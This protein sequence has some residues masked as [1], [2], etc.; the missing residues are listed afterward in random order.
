M[1]PRHSVLDVEDYD[2]L[3]NNP[4]ELIK[5]LRALKQ[6]ARDVLNSCDKAQLVRAGGAGAMSLE[7]DLRASFYLRVS[8]WPVEHLRNVL[9]GVDD[10]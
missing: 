6:A 2:H 1:S 4:E 7:N 3:L 10:D 9:E 8:A 5:R